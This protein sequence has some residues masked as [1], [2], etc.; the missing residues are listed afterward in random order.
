VKPRLCQ[1]A[2]ASACPDSE[3]GAACSRVVY[4]VPGQSTAGP[5]GRKLR[6]DVDE[7]NKQFG[8]ASFTM[9]GKCNRINQ[10]F[11]QAIEGR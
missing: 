5:S 4:G 2:V 8:C 3:I 9:D 6:L 7:L 11:V 10:C 1:H